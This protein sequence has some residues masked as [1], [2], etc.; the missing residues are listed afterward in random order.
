MEN[1]KTTNLKNCKIVIESRKKIGAKQGV[2]TATNPHAEGN[3]IG[4]PL[5]DQS[6]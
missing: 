2:K 1:D 6:N 4:N 5:R 3:R